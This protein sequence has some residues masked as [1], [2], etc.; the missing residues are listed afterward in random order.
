MFD[1]KRFSLLIAATA[2]VAACGGGGGTSAGSG[3]GGTGGSGGGTA[4]PG[5]PGT[6]VGEPGTPNQGGGNTAVTDQQLAGQLVIVANQ[7][8]YIR[9]DRS[10]YIP[11]KVDRFEDA[12]GID[13]VASGYTGSEPPPPVY[14]GDP[15]YTPDATVGPAAPIAAFGLRVAKLVMNGNELVRNQSAIGR[16]AV[17]MEEN[18]LA[19]LPEAQRERMRFVIDNIRLSTNDRGELSAEVLPNAQMHVYGRNAAGTEVRD[20]IPVPAR[21]V[22]MLP[23]ERVPDRFGDESSIVLLFDFENAFSLAGERL[24]ALHN[25]SGQFATNITVSSARILRPASADNTVPEKQ[26]V[27]AEIV[28]NDQPAVRGGGLIGNAWIRAY[29]PNPPV[30]DGK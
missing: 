9:R 27:G 16:V 18:P 1:R 25:I 12:N 10:M 26:L 29:N 14:N 4:A 7:I 13:D 21:A 17:S 8:V 22:R 15:A 23:M 6:N 5:T 24:R 20:T 3:T 2:L 28:V 19:G 11:V 30:D